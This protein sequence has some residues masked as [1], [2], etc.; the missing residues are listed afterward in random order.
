MWRQI[1]LVESDV[2][3]QAQPVVWAE[4]AHGVRPDVPGPPQ[5]GHPEDRSL[6]P[7]R[8]GAD[9]HGAGVVSEQAAY[10]LD[11]P[12]SL[13]AGRRR[14]PAC[15]NTRRRREPVSGRSIASVYTT[16]VPWH[17]MPDG[18][19]AREIAGHC[20]GYNSC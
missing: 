1:A 20:A 11:H 13:L 15:R 6:V 4:A 17:V 10:L 8:V 2:L 18:Q 19:P 3:E 5:C 16:F 7:D 14:R 12:R 9:L